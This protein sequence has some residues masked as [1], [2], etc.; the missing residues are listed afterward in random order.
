MSHCLS[1]A[2]S[3][4]AREVTESNGCLS[5]TIPNLITT[6]RIILTPIFIIYLLNEQLLSAL[7]VFVVCG[8][9][10]GLDGFLARLLKQKSVLGAYLDPI[11]DKLIL[12]SSFVVLAVMNFIPSWLAVI[13]ITRDV[14]ISLGVI[15]LLIYRMEIRIRPSILSKITTCLQFVTIIGVLASGYL[16]FPRQWYSVIFVL[17]G[18]FTISSGLHYIHTWFK[19]IGEEDVSKP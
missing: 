18:L 2:G 14:L 11:A 1:A 9:S 15:V 12:V 5:M 3:G 4:V 10:D 7:V 19:L 16:A 13:V 8:V 17:T 6:L